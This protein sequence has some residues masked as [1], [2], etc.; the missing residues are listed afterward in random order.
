MATIRYI[1]RDAFRLLF[2]HWGLTI[3]TWVTMM[4]VFL[5]VGG[6]FLLTSCAHAVVAKLAG[7][8]TIEA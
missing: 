1:L 2:R 7:D 6:S 4:A 5:A 3:L 8:L